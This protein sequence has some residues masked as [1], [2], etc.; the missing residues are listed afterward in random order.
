MLQSPN[1]AKSV[2]NSEI[3]YVLLHSGAA[4]TPATRRARRSHSGCCGRTPRGVSAGTRC[5]RRR[6]RVCS[7]RTGEPLQKTACAASCSGRQCDDAHRHGRLTEGLRHALAGVGRVSSQEYV[8]SIVCERALT[9][10]LPTD[11]PAAAS[12]TVCSVKLAGRR[13]FTAQLC[14]EN[15]VC[16]CPRTCCGQP[17][18]APEARM[19]RHRHRQ[20]TIPIQHLPAL[21][22]LSITTS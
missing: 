19:F 22:R 2:L 16:G 3:V 15:I 20:Q 12:H 7:W 21:H 6:R 13:V 10:V 11:G 18:W 1:P 4:C 5:R 17:S 8:Q 9:A 14:T